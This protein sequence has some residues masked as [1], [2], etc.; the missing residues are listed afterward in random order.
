[1]FRCATAL[2]DIDGNAEHQQHDTVEHSLGS[3]SIEVKT[4]KMKAMI[5]T[6]VTRGTTLP[7]PC[8]AIS[9]VAMAQKA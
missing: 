1:M 8:A 4:A 3:A 6:I 9:P 2:P 7:R 5:S